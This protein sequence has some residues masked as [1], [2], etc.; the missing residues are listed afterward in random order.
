[1]VQKVVKVPV[2]D[3]ADGVAEGMGGRLPFGR[4]LSGGEQG[5]GCGALIIPP[6][7]PTGIGCTRVVWEK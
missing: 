2:L 7:S 3:S 5:E 1:M 6:A 4:S